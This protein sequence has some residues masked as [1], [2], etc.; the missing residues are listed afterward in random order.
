MFLCLIIVVIRRHETSSFRWASMQLY[1]Y[2]YIYVYIYIYIII[3]IIKSQWHHRFPWLPLHPSI[4]NRSWQVFQTTFWVRIYK[5]FTSKAH[6]S[7]V[8]MIKSVMIHVFM[9]NSRKDFSSMWH[10]VY[11]FSCGPPYKT[12]FHWKTTLKKH[13]KPKQRLK[14]YY[15][16][17]FIYSVFSY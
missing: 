2:I 14:K 7:K 11:W 8:W 15:L 9:L 10:V 16:D 12:I 6:F 13:T 17:K 3:I 1:I 5:Q 4:T